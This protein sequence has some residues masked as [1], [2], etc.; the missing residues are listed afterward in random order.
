[1]S[2]PIRPE[3]LVIGGGLAGISAACHLLDQGL[4]VTLVEKRPFLGGR[5]Y[6]FRDPETGQ[7]VDNGQH[8]FL[9]CCTE[10]IDFL[11]RLGVFHKVHLQ[12]RF[13]VNVIGGQKEA[14]LSAAPLLPAPLHLLPSF[15]AFPYLGLAEKLRF[16]RAITKIYF[17]DRS[18]QKKGLEGKTFL[19]WL[20]EQGQSER[21]IRC[22]WE[23]FV[24]PSLNDRVGAVSAYQA[25]LVFQEG[26]LRG[27]HSANIGYSRAGLTALVDDG[28][29]RYIAENGGRLVLDKGVVGL[30]VEAGDGRGARVAWAELAGGE[31]LRA[32]AY[33]CAVPWQGFPKLLPEPWSGQPF[34]QAASR[35]EAAPIVGLHLWYDRPVTDL[36]FVA[37]LD[38]PVQWVFNKSRIMALPAP[39][40]Y[41]CVSLSGAWEYARM[42]KEELKALFSV[43]MERLFPRARE[44]RLERF[45]VVKQLQATF[46]PIPGA[47]ACRPSQ[48]TP[49]GNLFLAGDWTAT[50]WPS[51]MEGA[52]RSGRLAATALLRRAQE[53]GLKPAHLPTPSSG[54]P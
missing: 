9:G 38:S 27:R 24:L 3:I 15:L 21:A 32:D 7:E 26:L 19:H 22:L 28:A 36:E 43:E 16:L 49:I 50:G 42:E 35:L 8:V 40:Q 31:R 34:F 20:E 37:F 48:E 45:I 10:Y 13:H 41:L 11:K 6:S 51:T 12:R 5:A 18:K 39:G 23:L 53:L 54:G 25:F 1:M 46:R 52:V 44:A 30:H 33:V 4:S 17:T 14:A 47:E 2:G 29:R